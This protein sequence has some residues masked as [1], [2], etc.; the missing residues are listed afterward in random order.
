MW[1]FSLFESLRKSFVLLFFIPTTIFSQ[2]GIG[3][4]APVSS[5]KLEVASTTQGFLPPRMT[6]A[7]R[8][9][10]STPASGL[11][12]FDV[13]TN[14]IW[15]YD[16]ASWINT[17]S[18]A[19]YGDIKT[20][21]QTSDH[22]GWIKLDGRSKASLTSAQQSRATSLGIGANL[23]DA[24]DA[25]LVQ[26]GSSLGSVSGSN[27]KII[28]QSNLPNVTLSGNTDVSGVHNH[29]L[30]FSNSSINAGWA[31]GG[32]SA[33]YLVSGAAST[34]YSGVHSHTL[35]TS[36]INGGVSQVSLE[37]TPRSISANMFI[38]L[39]N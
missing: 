6:T 13:T 27:N 19:T 33:G 12:V 24:T 29:S 28:Q 21:I 8:S 23:P 25:F 26:N 3:T 37:I 11:M 22:N 34:S 16:G 18:V 1:E 4:N 10:I 15:Y 36:S 35:T 31:V 38:Y 14:S 5:A 30:G 20:G 39:G 2:V 7:Q 9:S 32:G 17:A